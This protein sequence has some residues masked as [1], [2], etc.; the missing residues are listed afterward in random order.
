[1][2]EKKSWKVKTFTTELK[3]FQTIRELEILDEKV[4]RFIAEN[5]VKKVVSVNDTTTT[6]NTGATIGLIRVL[7][8][9]T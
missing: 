9:E 2:G 6:D 3:I 5:N 1:M 8:Y 7:S 4:N